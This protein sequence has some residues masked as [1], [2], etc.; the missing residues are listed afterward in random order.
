MQLD[1][2][3]VADYAQAAAGK[4]NVIGG[5]FDTIWLKDV[6][7]I[8]PIVSLAMRFLISPGEFNRSHSLEVII[9]DA[10]G[11]KLATANGQM[12]VGPNDAAQSWKPA[13]V[14][15]TLNFVNLRFDRFG[16]YA[17]EILVNG[18]SLKSLPLEL[19]KRQ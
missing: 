11:K 10:D 19:A 3:F 14:V 7:A 9:V 8:Y 4:I 13:N 5:A 6:P 15:M 1:F 12:G 16:S 17:I 2:A 18:M